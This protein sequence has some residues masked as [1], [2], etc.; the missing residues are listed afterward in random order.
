[1]DEIVTDKKVLSR[2]PKATL[3]VQFQWFWFRYCLTPHRYPLFMR[4][5]HANAR[6]YWIGPIF[7]CLP[8]TWLLGPARSLHPEAFER[9]GSTKA[10]GQA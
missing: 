4:S 8:A 9:D 3:N 1:M 2:L 6:T 5:R 10:E 7:I